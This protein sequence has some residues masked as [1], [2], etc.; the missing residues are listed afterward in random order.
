MVVS[1]IFAVRK[2]VII[3]LD[4]PILILAVTILKFTGCYYAALEV[5]LR[6]LWFPLCQ[7]K[8]VLILVSH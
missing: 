7:L 6:Y 2:I 8:Q 4:S 1:A 5:A 3:V